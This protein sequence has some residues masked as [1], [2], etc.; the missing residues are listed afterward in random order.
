MLGL[1]VFCWSIS[2]SV[3]FAQTPVNPSRVE[4]KADDLPIATRIEIGVFLLGATHF[5]IGTDR[6][7]RR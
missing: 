6:T 1:L 7:K 2:P 4:L 5:D 3:L